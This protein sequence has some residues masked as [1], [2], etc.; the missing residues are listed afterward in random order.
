M[1]PLLTD[2]AVARLPIQGGR[3]A[4]LEEILATGASADD[5]ARVYEELRRR[6]RRWQLPAVAAA[7][8][9]VLVMGSAWWA[10]SRTDDVHPRPPAAIVSAPP[11]TPT[12]YRAV[13]DADGWRLDSSYEDPDGRTGELGYSRGAATLKIDWYP[14]SGYADRY[15]NRRLLTDPPSDG[16]PVEVLGLPSHLWAYSADDHTVL[17]PVQH[18]H[19]LE[20]RGSG[21]DE[22]S[23]VRVLH[24]LLLVDADGLEA[25][26]PDGFVSRGERSSQVASMLD[27]IARFARPLLPA[28]VGRDGITTVQSDPV[29]VGSDVATQVA[30]A[31]IAQYADARRRGDRAG[32]AEAVEVMRTSREWPVLRG[33]KDQSD[34]PEWVWVQADEMAA[35]RVPP[36]WE[37]SCRGYLP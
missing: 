18:G 22:R 20:I 30:C 1:K 24:R 10:G 25:A 7:V 37:P 21:M 35:G 36:G 19:F 31:W 2:E 5:P 11:A 4:L 17:R 14:A 3:A 8:V 9:A 13:L 28:S 29:Q 16:T 27:G 26:L 23:Y 15:A 32:A 6:R 33:M 34:V 12:P